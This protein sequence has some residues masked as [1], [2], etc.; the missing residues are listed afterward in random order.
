MCRGEFRDGIIP[1]AAILG[2]I[3]LTG[4]LGGAVTV[5]VIARTGNLPIFFAIGF[6]V[7]GLDRTGSARTSVGPVDSL[8]AVISGRTKQSKIT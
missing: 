1:K 7:P 8:A 5:H 2:A 3:L 4:Y 6:G